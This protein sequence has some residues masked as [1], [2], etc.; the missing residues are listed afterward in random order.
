MP[1]KLFAAIAVTGT[2]VVLITTASTA[3]AARQ[4]PHR[5]HALVP[6]T[7]HA[8]RFAATTRAKK[9]KGFNCIASC[10]AYE[11]T[12]NQYFT[13]VAA[14]SGTTENVYSVATQYSD[15]QYD[16]TFDASTNTY[17]DGTPYPTTHTC[18]DGYD[19]YCVTDAQ[20]RAEIKKVIADRGWP[21]Q[22]PTALYFIFTPANVGICEHAGSSSGSNY[23]T[24]NGFCA[25][26][27]W[28]PSHSFIYA[29]E[30]DAAAA[31]AGACTPE[32]AFHHAQAP[33][34]NGADATINT[35]SHEH[36][37]AITDPY[38]TGWYSN[39]KTYGNP[40]NGDLCAY[41]FGTPQGISPTEYNQTI[42]GHNYYLQLEYSNEA[43]SGAGGCVPYLGGPVTAADTTQN[44]VGPLVYQ[45]GEVMSKN[46]V[47]AIYWVPVRPA[48]NLVPAISGTAKVGQKLKAANG[49]WLSAA[50]FTYRWFRC[51]PTGAACAP[52]SRANRP[53]Y[54]LAAADAHHRLAVRVTGT[55]IAGSTSAR[56]EPTSI[57]RH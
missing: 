15:I 39:D 23:C 3:G 9:T 4:A 55:N 18:N 57:V 17:V 46:T 31:Y 10:A 51:S 28:T 34:G 32:D 53:S 42:N 54:T 47:Y 26:H 8:S 25:Y 6:H 7:E 14:D 35:I 29:V 12:I 50:K 5:I 20:L 33:A 48:N 44:G 1:V 13:D 19:K 27:N 43:N 2:A 16:V 45:G 49:K 22:S 41:D 21:T 52:I 37:E 11:S 30:P 40:E 36:N 24:T 38:G 56:S